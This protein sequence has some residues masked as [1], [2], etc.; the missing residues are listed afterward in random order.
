MG[1]ERAEDAPGLADALNAVLDRIEKQGG[2]LPSTIT[3]KASDDVVMALRRMFSA[4]AVHDAGAGR[5]RINFSK[6]IRDGKSSADDLVAIVYRATGRTPKNVAAEDRAVRAELQKGLFDLSKDARRESARRFAKAHATAIGSEKSALMVLARELGIERTRRLMCNVIRC[7][8]ALPLQEPTRAQAFA[9]RVLGNSKALRPGG[10]LHVLVSDALIS[11]DAQTISSLENVGI[12]TSTPEALEYALELNGVVFDESAASVVCFGPIVYAKHGDAYDQVKRH[13]ALGESSR[14]MLQQLRDA[15][16]VEAS[17]SRLTILENQATYLDYV[18]HSCQQ[19]RTD[20]I[21]VWSGGHPN[22]AVIQLLR[23]L[24]R[25][26]IPMRHSGDLDRSG[27][28]ILRTM[29]ARSACRIEPLN[30][31]AATHRRFADRGR[32]ISPDDQARIE[33]VLRTDPPHSP[34]HDLLLE[35]QA[36]R[37]WIEQEA[38]SDDL[39]HMW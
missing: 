16:I 15:E 3:I 29:M 23:L 4:G 33:R 14:L 32:E 26:E 30:M 36:T 38:F 17:A 31:D 28:L 34:G 21:V 8:E 20:E 35:L 11:H 2:R 19:K 24:R 10:E 12:A 1:D 6:A 18:D 5:V 27:V 9:A 22:N 37:R 13:A 39:L 25:F 7:L